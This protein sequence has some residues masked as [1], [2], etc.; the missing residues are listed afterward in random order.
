MSTNS[1]EERQATFAQQITNI[2]LQ[3]SSVNTQ[4]RPTDN[5]L[6]LIPRVIDKLFHAFTDHASRKQENDQYEAGCLGYAIHDLQETLGLTSDQARTYADHVI[7]TIEELSKK[8][9]CKNNPETTHVLNLLKE[10]KYTTG[11][12]HPL[13]IKMDIDLENT[14]TVQQLKNILY[15]QIFSDIHESLKTVSLSNKKHYSR[16]NTPL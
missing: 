12:D 5:T 9:V 4:D 13:G 2:L 16:V 7:V 15:P 8:N 14:T 10:H 11:Y 1:N 6:A 3:T